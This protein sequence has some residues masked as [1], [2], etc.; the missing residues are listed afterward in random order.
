MSVDLPTPPL[1][2]PMHRTFATC[3][4]APAGRLPRPS[5]C[6][7]AAFCCVGEHVEVDVHVRDAVE[8]ADGLRDG[9]LEVALDRAAGRGQGNG[10]VDDAVGA[11]VDRAH[12]VELDDRA[13][14]LGVDDDLEG[15]R[16]LVVGGHPGHCDKDRR[17][18]R[19]RAEPERLAH[20]VGA[21]S[22][23]SRP[24]WCCVMPRS[25][26]TGWKSRSRCLRW[27]KQKRNTQEREPKTL[28]PSPWRSLFKPRPPAERAPC[29]ESS[30]ARH[31]HRASDH[32]RKLG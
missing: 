25:I 10:H 2:E 29:S 12:H 21:A 1:P 32:A 6:C 31:H 24:G 5:F 19:R 3:A 27:R 28:S 14:Q 20:A 17:R 22:R 13:V 11:D 4:S 23:A 15:L 8:R 9:G 26:T 16:D 30:S 18:G 7:S